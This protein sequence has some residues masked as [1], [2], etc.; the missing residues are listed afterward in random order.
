MGYESPPDW[1]ALFFFFFPPPLFPQSP[2]PERKRG[3]RGELAAEKVK[4]PAVLLSDLNGNSGSHTTDPSSPGD[5][6]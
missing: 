4:R 6:P 1:L 2:R 3:K 5:V